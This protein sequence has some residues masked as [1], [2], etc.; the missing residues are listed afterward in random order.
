MAITSPPEK[1]IEVPT[2]EK[3]PEATPARQ[4]PSPMPHQAV[5]PTPQPAVTPTSTRLVVRTTFSLNS[6][7]VC[8]TVGARFF[9]ISVR[10][11]KSSGFRPELL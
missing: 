2:E 4:G 6:A 9:V 10:M 5:A 8:P 1:V 3:E 7:L 11:E